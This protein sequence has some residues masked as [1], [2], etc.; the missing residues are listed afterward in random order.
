MS[1]TLKQWTGEFGNDY[2]DRQKD[3]VVA[4]AELFDCRVGIGDLPK[5]GVYNCAGFSIIDSILEVGANTGQNLEALTTLGFHPDELTGLEPNAGADAALIQ[6]GF[7]VLG[8]TAT[9]IECDDETFDLV[10]TCGLLIHIPPDELDKA[11]KEI[12]RVSSRY[13]LAM[14][15]FSAE[16]RMIP[17]RGKDD[18]LWARDFGS[19]Y[20]D[21]GLEHMDHGF[22]WEPATTLDNINWW[23]FEKP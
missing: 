11:M 6:D 13:V 4:R 3:S 23:L 17:Y 22:A 1:E 19:L 18:M 9:D 2:T 7:N 21:M 8:N 16:P 10:F 14:E 20:L 15:Y 12:V 5:D